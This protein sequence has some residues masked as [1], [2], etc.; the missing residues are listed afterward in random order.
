[1]HRDWV[2]LEFDNKNTNDM[3][4]WVDTILHRL[5]T[6]TIVVCQLEYMSFGKIYIKGYLRL[7]KAY[8]KKTMAQWMSSKSVCL[9]G[10]NMKELTPYIDYFGKN[11]TYTMRTNAPDESI[12]KDDMHF[13][14][15]DTERDY[16]S[17]TSN[18]TLNS[19]GHPTSDSDE[20]DAY[21]EEDDVLLGESLP[22]Y[23]IENF[24]HYTVE[25]CRR[26]RILLDKHIQQYTPEDWKNDRLLVDKHVYGYT[27]PSIEPLGDHVENTFKTEMDTIKKKLEEG[28]T[29]L[30]I[31]R[32]HFNLWCHYNKSFK[33]YRSLVVQREWKTRVTVYYGDITSEL[34]QN[35]VVKSNPDTFV[36]SISEFMNKG[37]S[38]YNG[39]S[40]I[41]FLFGTTQCNAIPYHTL[42]NFMN[43]TK[44][45][46]SD[47]D[48]NVSNFSP[49]NM[50]IF[51]KKPPQSW[52]DI[53][54]KTDQDKE[55]N[56]ISKKEYENLYASI[57]LIYKV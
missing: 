11:D 9:K 34:V 17:T 27:H 10:M 41:V 7:P 36:L 51:S 25:D 19:Y 57:D 6:N 47:T 53:S 50:I 4:E 20:S 46:Y 23:N 32:D 40:D 8:K 1:M 24:R 56:T 15:A 31:S 26:D 28:I 44:M 55:N 33:R 22:R 13:L 21:I 5:P 43:S 37:L 29:E 30:E 12:L 18:D 52:Y 49:R 42:L 45:C 39:S 2:F 54:D 48:S 14:D 35:I 16:E 38:D 3:G